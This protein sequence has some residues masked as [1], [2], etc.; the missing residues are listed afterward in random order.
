MVRRLRKG[1]GVACLTALALLVS[2]SGCGASPQSD[3]ADAGISEVSR[4]SGRV[5]IIYG[6]L[7]PDKD[8]QKEIVRFN[9]TNTEYEIVPRYYQTGQGAQSAQDTEDAITAMN[10]DILSGNGP[11]ILSLPIR[12]SMDLYARKG[13]LEDLYPYLDADEG[14][15]R[16]DFLSNILG[17][18][19][20]DGSLYGIPLSF[21]IITLVGKQSLLGERED[22]TLEE[23]MDFTEDYL[24]GTDIFENSS[25]SGVLD[26]CLFT[27]SEQ[28]TKWEGEDFQFNREL[29][30]KILEYAARFPKDSEYMEDANYQQRIADQDLLLYS[31][32]VGNPTYYPLYSALFHEPVSFVGYPV[33]DGC[34]S[35]IM[36]Y[37]TLAISAK[38]QNKE[39]AWEFLSGLLSADA[40]ERDWQYHCPVRRDA[41]EKFLTDSLHQD[42]TYTM[43]IGED[44]SLDLQS[45][46]EEDVE[47]TRRLVE[48]LDRTISYDYT[49]TGIIKEEAGMY[50][51]GD[52]SLDEVTD[53]VENRV[54]LYMEE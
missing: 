12:Y 42:Y 43:S 3:T 29:F 46:T 1:K 24:P 2:L 40:Y 8:I 36:S 30:Q 54:R 38:S 17:A 48:R 9:D 27:Y 14:L 16:E 10:L 41:F 21:D 39:G 22:W 37:K 32:S 53:V 51:T 23:L 45:A 50:F 25:R 47:R 11:D 31:A 7:T 20:V 19:E 18:Y 5:Q 52:K 33:E 49:I 28:F 26:I 44:F 6:A 4:E 13:V 15:S 34:G 35:L